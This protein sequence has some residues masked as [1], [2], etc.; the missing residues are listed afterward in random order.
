M[1]LPVTYMIKSKKIAFRHQVAL[2]KASQKN[3][4]SI[5]MI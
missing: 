5:A 4:K 2:N 3:I 1:L